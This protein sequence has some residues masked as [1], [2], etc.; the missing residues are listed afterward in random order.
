MALSKLH[1]RRRPNLVELSTQDQQLDLNTSRGLRVSAWRN[2]LTGRRLDLAGGSELEV[3]VDSAQRRIWIEGWRGKP[4]QI[5]LGSPNQEAGYRGG[6]H[7]PELNDADWANCMNPTFLV[8]R[9]PNTWYWARTH[10]F[11]HGEDAGKP[12]TLTLGGMGLYDFR[13]MRV[14]INGKPAGVRRVQDLW[15]EPGQFDIGP[16]SAVHKH[17]RFGQD[18][19]IAL[20]L[21]R[22]IVRT[23][24]LDQWDPQG[25]FSLPGPS[26]H[27][28]HFEQYISVGKPTT[29]PRFECVAL[30]QTR[31]PKAGLVANLACRDLPLKARLTY[32]PQAQGRV[33]HRSVVLTNTG[34][35]PLRVMDIR[36]GDYHSRADV[37][38]GYI[39]SPVYLDDEFFTSLD[40]PAGWGRGQ[41]GHVSL[42]QYAGVVLEPGQSYSCMNTVFGVA[43]A[44]KAQEQFRQYLQGR[45]RRIQRGHDKPLTIFEPYGGW[46]LGPA[47]DK[48]GGFLSDDLPEPFCL[49]MVKQLSDF[50]RQ[51]GQQFDL[52]SLEFWADTHGDLT[53]FKPAN[54]PHGFGP[55]KRALAKERLVPGMWIA[56][57]AGVWSIGDNPVLAP[58]R[59][60]NASY[61]DPKPF[62]HSFCSASEP[63]G[64]IF[65]NGMLH[66]VLHNGGRLLKLDCAQC[67]CSNVQ[68]GH[69]G[70]VY[71]TQAIFDGVIDTLRTLDRACP[72]LFIMLYGGFHS[73]WW[74]LHADTIYEPGLYMEAASPSQQPSLYAR[75]GVAVTLDQAH[76][77]AGDVPRLGK[78]SLGVW[79]SDWPWNSGIGSARWAESLV[80][81]LCRGELLVQVWSDY[82]W[83]T[84]PQRRRF[85]HLMSLVRANPGCFANSNPILSGAWDHKPYGYACCDGQR[86]FIAISN[87]TWEDVK[88]PLDLAAWGLADGGG[89][90][91]YEQY[92]QPARLKFADASAPCVLLRPFD[93][94][95]LEAAP[96]G[97]APTGNVRF[98]VRR[99][100]SAFAD[101]SCDIPLRTRRA[102]PSEGPAIDLT[103][104]KGSGPLEALPED[105]RVRQV[106]RVSGELAAMS[107]GG[108]V[109]ISARM[110]RN[111]KPMV[112]P[113]TGSYFA[114]EG[115]LAGRA[116]EPEAVLGQR[117]YH[118]SWQAWRIR[119]GPALGPR[120]FEAM[121]SA[122][123]PSDAHLYFEAHLVRS[124]Q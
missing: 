9:N 34:K 48:Y 111:H 22:P 38:E 41:R 59:M 19:I 5:P 124:G 70:G 28:G 60:T 10:V 74:L 119:I 115:K 113:L 80:M 23:G 13:Y 37:S 95:L 39:G 26:A 87:P 76:A 36:L 29:T 73:P 79:L 24:K 96:A 75:D 45:M 15:H 106:H 99:V 68:H 90:D 63:F 108:T 11:L 51:T 82:T 94:V 27:P 40:H 71:S 58:S 117:C 91:I 109:V 32:S 104:L 42:R 18:N 54:F 31:S 100:R 7:L 1:V 116:M 8:W 12:L 53:Q 2:L 33:I 25:M 50:R 78:D 44:G 86:A 6:F 62:S 52:F 110:I 105:Q 120:R 46:K 55:L 85:A 57:H 122:V 35:S 3:D 49:H 102:K 65:T 84:R 107:A 114:L 89:H 69:L 92:P 93:V 72:E 112:I 123:L 4:S 77:Y 16:G 83:L 118:A 88:V 21:A 56:T 61:T 101:A 47:D 81:D 20:Q 121:V 98:P 14:F 30:R 43:Q 67:L 17:L 103:D 66:Q 64:S 97:S